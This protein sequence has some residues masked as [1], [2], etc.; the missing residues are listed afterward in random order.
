MVIAAAFFG[1]RLAAPFIPFTWEQKLAGRAAAAVADETGGDAATRAYLQSLADRLVPAM[2]LPDDMTITVHFVEDD[3]IN[4]FATLG[5]HIVVFDGLW[6]RLDS[7][8]A[9]AMLLAHEIAHVKNRDP[10]RSAS[11]ALLA[12]LAAG[13]IIG[14]VAIL[15]S[16]TGTGNLLT[17]LHFSRQ[18]ETQADADAAAAVVSLYGHLDGA[19]D[20][21]A[22]LQAATADRAAPPAF[23]ASHPHLDDRIEN[24]RALAAANAWLSSGDK[25]PLPRNNVR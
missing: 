13:A 24:L 11:G 7:E 17:A 15:G 19:S 6:R 16:V 9:A 20:L 21:F 1:A 23:L 4:A 25:T 18:Q 10:I 14:D 12:A 2:A 8:N 22:I 3:T 5:G